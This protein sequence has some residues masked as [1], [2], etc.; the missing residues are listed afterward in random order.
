MLTNQR[1]KTNFLHLF[2][3]MEAKKVIL[4]LQTMAS[5]EYVPAK[6]NAVYVERRTYIC[7]F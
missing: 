4:S 3:I 6:D 2:H 5:I 1:K 7:S